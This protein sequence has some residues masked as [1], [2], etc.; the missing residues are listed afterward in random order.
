LQKILSMKAEKNK[1]VSLTYRLTENN[2]DGVLIEEVK[3]NQPFVFLFGEGNIIQGFEQNVHNLAVG[4][5]FAFGVK[6]SDAYG[7]YNQEGIVEL[8]LSIFENE[9]IL[10]TEICKVG[11]IV[12]MQNE[13]GH[14]FNGII[15]DVSDKNVTMDFNHPLAGMDLHFEGTVLDIRDATETELQQGHLHSGSDE[16]H[17]C[18]CGC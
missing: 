7:E 17:S 5:S 8:P 11:N 1:V 10:D 9:G 4:D 16:G 18:G 6:C 12:P 3:E 2:A 13:Q 15:K 14:Q